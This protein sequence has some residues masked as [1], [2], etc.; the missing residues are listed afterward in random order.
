MASIHLTYKIEE[1]F[2]D[3]VYSDLGSRIGSLLGGGR[4]V[5]QHRQ[6]LSQKHLQ[7]INL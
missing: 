5:G 2:G 1:V 3:I 6:L 4:Q 7:K